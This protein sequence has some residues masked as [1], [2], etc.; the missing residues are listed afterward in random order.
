MSDIQ[1]LPG[2][3]A[4]GEHRVYS[5]FY[6]DNNIIQQSAIVQPK[7][8]LIDS[9]RHLF[10][11]DNIYTYRTDEYGYPLTPDMTGKDIDSNE[12]T[13][14]LINDAYRYEVKYFPSIV[15][16]SNGG[17]Y[18]PISFN[19]NSTIKH[20]VDI[21]Q[22]DYGSVREVKTPTHRVYA[23]MWDLSFEVG[24]YSESHT[25]LEELVDIVSIGL[26]YKYW[27]DLRANG[28]FIKG[29]SIAG[30]SAEPYANDYVYSQN[31]TINT[32]SEWRV[33]I[34]LDNVIEK[35]VFYFDSV[36]TPIP[37]VKDLTDVQ[38]LNYS[39]ILQLSSVE[40]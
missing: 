25:E 26:Q 23:G 3:G 33:E 31:I 35:L 11:T 36:M 38:K 30:E 27:N 39:D 14:I 4:N 22:D 18:K 7:N 21:V 12:T 34:P 6:S 29:L 19:Q 37:G 15:I 32:Y 1:N 8:L 28:L 2:T 17:S 13:K 9:L 24:I 5:N 20:R 16:K 10:S 40:L